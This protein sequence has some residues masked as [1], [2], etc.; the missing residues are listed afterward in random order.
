MASQAG[1]CS[2]RYW[3]GTRRSGR[4]AALAAAGTVLFELAIAGIPTIATYKTDLFIRLMLSR[5]RTWSA[6]LPN[7]VAD[8]PVFP[9]FY[10]EFL[11]PAMLARTL[12]RLSAD[13]P[14]RVAVL[15]GCRDV[16]DKMTTDQPA[17]VAAADIVLRYAQKKDPVR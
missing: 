14:Q 16:Y 4:P 10:D 5:I 2:Q 11:R 13:T 9:E 6:A 8:Y 12:E 3:S 7:L 1:A 17:N 15:S